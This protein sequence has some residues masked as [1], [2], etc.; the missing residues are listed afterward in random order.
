MRALSIGKGRF[1]AIILALTSPAV[2][3]TPISKISPQYPIRALNRS[4]EGWVEIEFTI[5]V[6]GA[7][8]APKVIAAMPPGTFDKAALAAVTQW[9]YPPTD[10]E[11]NHSVVV[12]FSMLQAGAARDA[13]LSKIGDAGRAAQEKRFEDAEEILD[14]LEDDGGLT[15]IELGAIERV[16][17]GIDYRQGRLAD[18]ARRYNRLLEMLGPRMAPLATKGVIENLV[19]ARINAADFSGAV[20]AADR[21]LPAGESLS[22]E[23]TATLGRIRAALASGRPITL[24]PSP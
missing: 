10:A 14:D 19:T 9:R 20:A 13:V 5:G 22:P 23:L 7:V 18:A 12:T 16:Q 6:D 3:E 17:A 11:Q 2:A 15:L 4:E 1:V 24:T 8:K 21:W